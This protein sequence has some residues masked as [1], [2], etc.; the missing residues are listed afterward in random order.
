VLRDL[1][2]FEHINAESPATT[3][4]RVASQLAVCADGAS[5]VL[6]AEC[7]GV[8]VGYLAAHW[9]PNLMKG[10]DGYISELFLSEAARGQG[11]GG[12]L[13]AAIESEA[14]SHGVDRLI[15]FNRKERESWRRGFYVEHGWEAREDST[16][17]MRWLSK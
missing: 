3:T 11:I 13:L 5:T 12:Q 16:L 7:D 17:F 9:F 10:A 8:V 15:L 1:G 6:A 4:Q 2:W 14:R